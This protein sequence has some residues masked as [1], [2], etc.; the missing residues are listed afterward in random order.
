MKILFVGSGTGDH[1][2]ALHVNR[3][4]HALELLGHE[5]YAYSFRDILLKRA[6][7]ED[8]VWRE[9]YDLCMLQDTHLQADVAF[10]LIS[11]S[12]RYVLLTHSEAR[13][14]KRDIRYIE[15]TKPDW[16]FTDQPVG[17]ELFREAGIPATWMGHGADHACYRLP[18][19]K[20]DILWIGNK[21]SPRDEI[22]Q[23]EVVPLMN[24]GYNMQMWG[25]GYQK[26]LAKPSKM[27]D[28]MAR[29]KIVI[30]VGS[31][32]AIEHGYSGTRISDALASGCYVVSNVYPRCRERYPY[33]VKFCGTMEIKEFVLDAIK[34]YDE[35]QAEIELAYQYVR[36]NRMASNDM[37]MVLEIV[38]ALG[39]V[40]SS[41]P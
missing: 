37:Q 17:P 1:F 26:G 8:E 20:I 5:V 9:R 13:Q 7:K 16:I 40:T 39:G 25:Q 14:F 27:F 12:R 21:K 38:E 11:R 32:P 36:N 34:R 19:K 4:S 33:G 10:S 23:R 6:I 31:K 30:H 24:A 22:V 3:Y 41:P 35:L 2:W 18:H 28:L 15:L 29:S